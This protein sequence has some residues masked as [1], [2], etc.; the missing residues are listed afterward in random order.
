M[1]SVDIKIGQLIKEARL[2]KKMTQLQLGQVVGYTNSNFISVIEQGRQKCPVNTLGVICLAL[3]IDPLL[4][5]R[6]LVDDHHFKIT[7]ELGITKELVM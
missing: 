4:V 7:R 6:M 1:S 2:K 3:K 5:R